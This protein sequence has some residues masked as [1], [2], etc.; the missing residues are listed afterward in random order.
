MRAVPSAYKWRNRLTW[1]PGQGDVPTASAGACIRRPGETGGVKH[2]DGAYHPGI[3]VNW[4]LGVTDNEASACFL[5][6]GTPRPR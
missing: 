6:D 3:V 4:K 1:Y 2:G 5:L